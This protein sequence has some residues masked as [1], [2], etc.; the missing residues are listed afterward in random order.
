MTERTCWIVGGTGQETEGLGMTK[1]RLG[2]ERRDYESASVCLVK[3]SAPQQ[4]G[5]NR[6]V[7]LI[8]D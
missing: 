2:L 1:Y 6:E 5:R 8:A 7:A 4:S 3:P